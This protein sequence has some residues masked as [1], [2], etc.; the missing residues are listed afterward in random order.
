MCV[1]VRARGTNIGEKRPMARAIL[2]VAR[3]ARVAGLCAAGVWGL[4]QL[5][6]ALLDHRTALQV[7]PSFAAIRRN[8]AAAAAAGSSFVVK[9]TRVACAAPLS[10]V[11]ALAQGIRVMIF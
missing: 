7:Q 1:V 10:A 2:A 6:H 4:V 9:S 3:S 5:C 8:A 11:S